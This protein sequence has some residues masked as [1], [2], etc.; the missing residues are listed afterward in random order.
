VAVCLSFIS[1]ECHTAVIFSTRPH[2]VIWSYTI[3][4]VWWWGR[5]WAWPGL[6]PYSSATSCTAWTPWRPVTPTSVCK[7]FCRSYL[8]QLLKLNYKTT[9]YRFI[10][11]HLIGFY[12]YDWLTGSIT[13]HT[14]KLCFAFF[15]SCISKCSGWLRKDEQYFNIIENSFQFSS[16]FGGLI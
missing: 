11:S 16:H 5:I 4:S 13:N 12:P 6:R 2:S 8:K 9:I 10:V 14:I 15:W 7:I 1:V 3:L